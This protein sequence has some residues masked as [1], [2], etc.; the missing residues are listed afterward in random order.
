[1]WADSERHGQPRDEAVEAI[2]RIGHAMESYHAD[3]S[4]FLQ[5]VT[6]RRYLDDKRWNLD[7]MYAV[8][9]PALAWFDE[10]FPKK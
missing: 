5:H 1:M 2:R 9:A 7:E 8:V 3:I 6:Q 10:A 4:G